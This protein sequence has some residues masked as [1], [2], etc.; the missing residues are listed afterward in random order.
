MKTGNT[1]RMAKNSLLCFFTTLAAGFLVACGSDGSGDFNFIGGGTPT[2][3]TVAMTVIAPSS[4][5]VPTFSQPDL[6]TVNFSSYLFDTA[7]EGVEYSGPTGNGMTGEGGVFLASEGVFEFSIADTALGSVQIRSQDEDNAVTP[8]DFIGVVDETQVITIARIMQALDEDNTLQNGISISQ[9]TRD[10]SEGVSLLYSRVGISD[11]AIAGNSVGDNNK[12]YTI[13]SVA[14]A[15]SHLADTRKCLFSGG[16]VGD[17]EGTLLG[18]DVNGQSYYAVEPFVNRVRR[19]TGDGDQIFSTFDETSAIGVIGSTITLSPGNELSFIT[20]RLVTGVL[21]NTD[22][23]GNTV[24]SSADNLTLAVN[25]GNPSATRRVV[26]VETTNTVEVVAGMYVLDYFEEAT[27]FRGQYYSVDAGG[28]ISIVPLSLT[29]ANGGSWPTVAMTVATMLTLSGDNATI[30]VGVVRVD[31]NYGS[32]DGVFATGV[33]SQLSGTWCD[34]G[35]A[36]GSTVAPTPPTPSIEVIVTWNEVEG[37]TSYK[38]Y[39]ATMTVSVG[40]TVS[41]ANTQVGG[42]ISTTT[43]VDTPPAGP[44]YFYRLQACNSAG[45]SKHPFGP[46]DPAAGGGD[47]GTV[48]MTMTMTMTMTVA[49]APAQPSV[50]SASAQSDTEIEVTWDA[51]SLAT[52][53]NLYR[54]TVSG[55]TSTLQIGGDLATTTYT[56]SELSA[57]TD[58]FYQLEACNSA[59]CSERSPEVSVTTNDDGQCDVGDMLAIGE[60]CIWREHTFMAEA[61]GLSIAGPRVNSAPLN[62]NQFTQEEPPSSGNLL[63]ATRSGTTWEITR[64]D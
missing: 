10:D 53:Y 52:T 9:A 28:T 18:T 11:E 4:P 20:P 62:T 16:Y 60:S 55:V 46:P 5:G 31:E 30:T 41:V 12:Q 43:Y 61:G 29:I 7:A 25:T 36:V 42:D 8:A 45:C 63:M 47:G 3:M 6:P 58:Y 54:A 15:K 37:A 39:R 14:N 33:D 27:V 40:S 48:A 2:P 13:P 24:F 38:L 57:N 49:V 59:G 21:Q 1:L 44:E 26:G 50:P 51:V 17:F 19:F 32:F 22:D 35:G 56:D 23:D 34:I 64:A